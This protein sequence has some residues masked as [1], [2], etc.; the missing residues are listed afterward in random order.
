ME[1]DFSLRMHLP[2]DEDEEQE[3]EKVEKTSSLKRNSDKLYWLWIA[4]IV[5]DL[6]VQSLRSADMSSSR[7]KFISKFGTGGQRIRLLML[8]KM[9]RKP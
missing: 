7:E 6:V 4:I 5:F 9:R 3:E 8:F 2:K 1:A